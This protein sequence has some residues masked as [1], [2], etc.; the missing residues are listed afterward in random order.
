MIQKEVEFVRL[1]QIWQHFTELKS[2]AFLKEQFENNHALITDCED[3]HYAESLYDD[4]LSQKG[5]S[6]MSYFEYIVG[7]ET[8]FSGLKKIVSDYGLKNIDYSGFKN[9]FELI[10]KPSNIND[11]SPFT[12]VEPLLINE[13]MNKLELVKLF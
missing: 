2:M 13:G 9:T 3:V 5:S 8:I 7:K 1:G 6:V 4:F 10:L 11:K 12:L